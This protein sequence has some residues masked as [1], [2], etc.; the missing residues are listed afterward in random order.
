M[1]PIL[2]ITFL[3]CY[4][5][6]CSAQQASGD[7]ALRSLAKLDIGFQGV[8]LAYEARMGKRTTL[9]LAAGAGGGYDVSEDGVGYEWNILQPAFYAMVTPKLYY[10]RMKRIQKGKR[11]ENNTGNYLGLRLKFA[12]GSIASNDYLRSA[13]LFNVHWG[14]QRYVGRRW[15]LNAHFG[16]GYAQDINS[17]F[18]TIYPAIDFKF[19][20]VFTRPRS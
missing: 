18:G 4:F 15:I 20:Y 10:N 12:S 9:E 8:G 17:I 2:I 6:N 11:V 3:F 1:K 5:L 13:A 16:A 14:M 19:S 7:S